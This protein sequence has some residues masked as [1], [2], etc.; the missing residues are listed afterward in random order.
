[1]TNCQ[2]SSIRT[3]SN[4]AVSSSFPVETTFTDCTFTQCYAKQAAAVRI[5]FYPDYNLDNDEEEIPQAANFTRCFFD[6]SEITDPEYDFDYSCII[7]LDSEDSA[8]VLTVNFINSTIQNVLA[9]G[10]LSELSYM[11]IENAIFDVIEAKMY[12]H[13]SALQCV[14]ETVHFGHYYI[15][16]KTFS[17]LRTRLWCNERS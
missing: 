14:S 16:N 17:E 15:I 4:E 13:S 10:I 3:K 5:Y 7:V 11:N 8:T 1:M 12:G 2:I 6:K 9:F